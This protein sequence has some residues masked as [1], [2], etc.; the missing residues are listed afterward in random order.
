MRTP[1]ANR[2]EFLAAASA[3][4]LAA[5]SR[6]AGPGGDDAILR[7]ALASAPDT[8][9]PLR[10]QLAVSALMFKQLHAPLTEYAPSGGVAP[11]LADGWR[12]DDGQ[13]WIFR[14][15]PDLVWSDGTPLTSEDVVWTAQR[16][17]DP[18]TGF[19]D[20]GDFFAVEG[21][22]E[23]VAGERPPEDIAVE[24]PDP[25][26]VVFRLNQPV[27]LFPVFMREFYPLPRHAIEPAPEAW[28]RAAG[29][30]SAG[31]YVLAAHEEGRYLLR[32]NRNFHAAQSVSIPQ[33]EVE[34]V[35]N[36]EARA[37]RFR[38]GEFDICEQPPAGE[39][40][41]LKAEFGPE[42][43]SFNAPT[44]TY[45]KLN[46]SRAPLN[47]LRVR[48]AISLSIDRAFLSDTLFDA[49]A[50]PTETVIPADARP[51]PADL[52]TAGALL[53]AAG[54]GP[55]RPLRLDLRLIAGGRERMAAAIMRDLA[56][57]HVELNLVPSEALDMFAAVDAGDFDLSLSRFDRGLKSDPNF[58]LQ[59]FGPD[60]FADDGGW[61]GLVREDF[62]LLMTQARATINANARAELYRRAEQLLLA[63]Q[64]IV[65]LLH[66]R[67]FWLIGDRVEGWR[68][69][70]PPMLWRDLD[71]D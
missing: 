34:V 47:D 8:L 10:G 44:L 17:V 54:Y 57:V 27:G 39:I 31:P 42:L 58:M 18:M 67:T 7:V 3:L 62:D 46:H 33:I 65:P 21:A 40:S 12:S 38:A 6:N 37:Q 1:F 26:T 25:R 32:R 64:A 14:L 13:L 11:G 36:A 45:L 70:I 16:A 48:Q 53:A 50:S 2:R 51:A 66:E 4:S 63:E 29:W 35:E 43:H 28:T 5:C 20:L 52:D 9:D 61:S 49:E 60:G 55:E 22:R 30:V 23:A 69:E 56:R 59:P 41:A 71:L 68:Q 19:A 15:N 24:A